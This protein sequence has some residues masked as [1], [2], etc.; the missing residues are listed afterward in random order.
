MALPRDSIQIHHLAEDAESLRLLSEFYHGLYTI[1]FP[2]S[3]ERELLENMEHYLQLRR[4]G[5]YQQNNYYILILTDSGGTICGGIIAD[6]FAR[7]NVGVI[8]F[9]VVSS[10]RRGQGLG[11]MLLGEIEQHFAT[12]ATAAGYSS[13]NGICGEVNDPYR[14]CEVEE[15]LDGFA[16]LLM[17]DRF[18]FKLLDFP[19]VQ[20]ALSEGQSPVTGLGLM[21]KPVHT[22]FSKKI[23]ASLVLNI[24]ADYQIWAMRIPTPESR[25]EY[26]GMRRSLIGKQE[27][28]LL[29][30]RA[31]SCA[32]SPPPFE[33]VEIRDGDEAMVKAFTNIYR[34]AFHD[35]T[36]AVDASEFA[37]GTR[38]GQTPVPHQYWMW[39]IRPLSSEPFLGLASF[40]SFPHCGFAGYAALSGTLQRKEAIRRLLR[41]MEQ[42]IVRA[43][44]VACGWYGE[45]EPNSTASRI[46]RRFGFSR[47]PMTYRQPRL[48]TD[49]S[50]KSE[51]ITLELLFKPFGRVYAS[52][53][54]SLAELQRDLREILARVY[55]LD[56]TGLRNAMNRMQWPEGKDGDIFAESSS[57]PGA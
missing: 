37:R 56:E 24:V 25:P 19:Y 28:N 16:R 35:D 33:A 53:S 20:P 11:K 32:E 54:L 22:G 15:H 9:M 34:Q 31:Y 27:V 57:Q 7:S 8:E 2:D 46:A 13:L 3:D 18:G 30:L 44:P 51:G 41:L 21:F 50:G 1:E 17:W 47:V 48:H 23:P 29:N 4:A 55:Y 38:M 45:C 14:R 12:A 43:N 26:A 39:G 5:W 42:Q 49:T 40:F 52:P 10:E 6:Y 36:T